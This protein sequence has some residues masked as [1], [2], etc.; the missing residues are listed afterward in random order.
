MA[1]M[2]KGAFDKIDTIKIIELNAAIKKVE[3]L[4][5]LFWILR[6]GLFPAIFFKNS[7][8]VFIFPV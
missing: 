7:F 2:A 8:T 1:M 3:T 6:L 4:N 5:I